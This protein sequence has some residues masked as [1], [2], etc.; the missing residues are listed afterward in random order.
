[1]V[2]LRQNLARLTDSDRRSPMLV[3]IGVTSV[4]DAPML[5]QLR[6][7]W[8]EFG[9]SRPISAKLGLDSA[10]CWRFRQTR[11]RFR[12]NRDMHQNMFGRFFGTPLT[13]L[14]LRK[15][16]EMAGEGGND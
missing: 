4:G 12:K 15:S 6:R 3:D 13:D 1:M 2:K 11:P 16:G 14:A 7:T 10:V 5:A 9:R 8:F